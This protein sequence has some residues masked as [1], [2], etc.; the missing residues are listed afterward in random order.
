MSSL[1]FRSRAPVIAVGAAIAAIVALP[2][3]AEERKAS[4][5]E[6]IGVATGFV[7]GAVAAG[8]VGAIVG[9]AAGAWL[10]DRYHRQLVQRQ[11]LAADLT[12]SEA[13]R[14]QLAQNL[15]QVNTNL[16]EEQAARTRLDESLGHA[17]ELATD[18]SFRT[19]DATLT[20]D[21]AVQ[22]KTIGA[23]ALG[24]P[25]VKV[26]VCGYADPRGSKAY[27]LALSRTRAEVVAAALEAA[28]LSEDRIVIEAHGADDSASEPG[29]LDGY[30]LERRVTVHLQSASGGALARAD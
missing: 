2:T 21:Q 19:D 1:T 17:R 9:T 30:A 8:P 20:A 10:G 7:V 12:A 11:A 22:L 16:H 28:G 27:N 13:Q 25:D 6:N 15:T 26:Q 14:A 24:L 23:L 3:R 18:F 5:Q 29:D 4:R